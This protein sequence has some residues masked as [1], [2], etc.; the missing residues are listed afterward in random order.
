MRK[1]WAL[2]ELREALL[3][4]APRARIGVLGL[5]YKEN[6]HSVK[7]SAALELIT[8]LAAWPVRAFDPAVPASAAQHPNLTAATNALD[9]ARDVD[10]LAIMTPWPEFRE[11]PPP[12][13]LRASC[14][15]GWFSTHTACSMPLPHARPGSTIARSARERHDTNRMMPMTEVNLLSKLPRGKRNVSARATA[16]TEEHIAHLARVR[17]S[18]FRRPARIWLR[19]LPL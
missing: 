4:T 11:D 17:R 5:A 15:A 2:R 10:A 6:T 8:Q 1:D 14:A 12:P 19:R 13:I 18:L 7:N 16:K 3:A 9:T